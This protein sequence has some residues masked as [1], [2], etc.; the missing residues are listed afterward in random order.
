MYWGFILF[1]PLKYKSAQEYLPDLPDSQECEN[2]TL[3]PTD[4]LAR[5]ADGVAAWMMR[6][7]AVL[8][9]FHTTHSL[10]RFTLH[11][12]DRRMHAFV[13][14]G[15]SQFH[16]YSK[17]NAKKRKERE[18]EKEEEGKTRRD[19]YTHHVLLHAYIF[20]TPSN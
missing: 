2:K 18:E 6:L 14:V 10:Q 13:F 12:E 8:P 4:L 15:K 11:V 7:I 5:L 3:A 19:D 16:A 20:H 9:H 1:P 17:D